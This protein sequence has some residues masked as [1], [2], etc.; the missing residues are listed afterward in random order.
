LANDERAPHAL[1]REARVAARVNHPNVCQIY[2]ISDDYSELFIA[3][4]LLD[5]EALSERLRKR[6]LSI[7]DALPSTSEF[8]LLSALHSG[9][10]VHRDLKPS[11][12][13]LT[14]HSVKLLDFGLA[15]LVSA[16]RR[17]AN[18][19]RPCAPANVRQ[20]SPSRRK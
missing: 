8:S 19:S 20:H 6:P 17:L 3:M 18:A 7:A 1:W 4:E 9:G 14:P 12:V 11:N 2:D 13:F 5:G 15:R 16:C 10:I